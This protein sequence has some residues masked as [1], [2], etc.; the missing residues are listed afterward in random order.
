MR[1]DRWE[2]KTRRKQREFSACQWRDLRM[3][4]VQQN[5]TATNPD[6]NKRMG[7]YNTAVRGM[8][9]RKQKQKQKH[10]RNLIFM[11]LLSSLH[12]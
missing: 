5:H 1:S 9:P 6:Q 2:P 4:D 10:D 7:S 12:F 8:S 11:K 3:T